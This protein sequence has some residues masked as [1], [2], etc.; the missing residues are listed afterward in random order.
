MTRGVGGQ[1]SA[2]VTAHLKGVNFPARKQDLVRQ[3][4]N[5]GA[6]QDVISMIQ[7]LPEQDY[8]SI[9]D[10]TRAFGEAKAA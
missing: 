3:A 8:K 1:S 6:G 7:R 10:V 2:N 9:A 4:Q 5:N